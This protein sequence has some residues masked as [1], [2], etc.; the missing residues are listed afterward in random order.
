MSPRRTRS[1]VLFSI[2][3]VVLVIVAGCAVGAWVLFSYE[4]D[5][6]RRTLAEI[7]CA[8]GTLRVL[9]R[10]TNINW[11]EG[12]ASDEAG[13]EYTSGG[14][15]IFFVADAEAAPFHL[16]ESARP[17][18][19]WH[20]GAEGLYAHFFLDPSAVP[21][22]AATA[23]EACVEAN[24]DAVLDALDR[25][26]IAKS[27][28][29]P[30]AGRGRIYWRS[31]ADALAVEFR[32]GERVVDVQRDGTM[33]LKESWGPGGTHW[34]L[35]GRV[36]VENGARVIRCC[37]S[38]ASIQPADLASYRDAS[39]RDPMAFFGASI[40]PPGESP[41]PPEV[42]LVDRGDTRL[43]ENPALVERI[44][45]TPHDYFRFVNIQFG[46]EVCDHFRARIAAM[47]TVNL[48]GDA[49]LEQYAVTEIGA[50]LAD[51]DDSSF[52][53][54]VLDLVRFGSSIA[55]AAEQRGFGEYEPAMSAFLRGYREALE[56]PGAQ[57][58]TTGF[59]TRARAAFHRE[60]GEFLSWATGLM[61]PI[62]DETRFRERH[63]LYSELMLAEE[64]RLAR[65]FFVLDRAGT[66]EMG[67]GS[68]LDEKYLARVR[69]ASA[70]PDDDVI[71][72]YKSVRDIGGIDCVRGGDGGAFRILVAQSR[73]GDMPVR[74]LAQVPRLPDDPPEAR[75]FWV[76]EWLANY[77]EL[78][79]M[80][81]LASA[82]ELVEIAHDVGVQLGKGHCR[83]IAS[84]LDSQLR[85]AS[86]DLLGEI[87][88][89]IVALAREL[90]DRIRAAWTAFRGSAE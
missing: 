11:F 87:E 22:A 49:H 7:Q 56:D 75:P 57:R 23:I 15:T 1:V 54:A 72:E 78:D 40:A 6:E 88:P 50:G 63:R 66:F 62:A 20:D 47:P 33:G 46:S 26:P 8:D 39:G 13:A 24:A 70:S 59:A 37:E 83:A 82:A 30:I 2:L 31:T 71:L 67:I 34:A 25:A 60:R 10:R 89:E 42:L 21:P 53:P 28:G 73:I 90:A 4:P 9:H 41:P 61:Q 65:D 51:F 16:P 43:T 45:S 69:G 58:V 32:S 55:L 14:Q 86:L 18:A 64:P 68:A 19:S 48:H 52:G 38:S 80:D 5:E 85:R 79:V 84:P 81:D 77:K 44:S 35:A 36:A 29:H 76:R 3:G 27:G 17:Q 12:V 74:F